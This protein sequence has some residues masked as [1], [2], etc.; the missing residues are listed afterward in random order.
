MGFVLIQTDVYFFIY[1]WM[2]ANN[3]DNCIHVENDCPTY[4][5]F[6]KVFEN[7]DKTKM[8]VP[9]TC[10][11]WCVPSLLYINKDV[12]KEFIDGYIPMNSGGDMRNLANAFHKN[13]KID[14]LPIYYE[15]LPGVPD[16]YSKHF[17]G[18]LFDAAAIGQYLGGVDPRNAKEDPR[19]G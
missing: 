15:Q 10:Q 5:N 4:I 8:W 9:M 3:I 14:A 11:W 16:F 6:D 12:Y 18:L 13:N 7:Y 19:F 1:E 2:V 17:N